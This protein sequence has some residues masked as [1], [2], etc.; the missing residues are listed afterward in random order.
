MNIE[1]VAAETPEKIL[2]QSIDPAA[3]IQGFHCRKIAFA[4]GLEGGQI[5][6]CAKLLGALYEAFLATDAS[7]A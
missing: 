4:L 6:A 5:K 7:T 1:E 2:L 3:G